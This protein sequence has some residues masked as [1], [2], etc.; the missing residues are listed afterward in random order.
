VVPGPH[1]LGL[2]VKLQK[3]TGVNSRSVK[4]LK[5]IKFSAK[6][7]LYLLGV[8]NENESDDGTSPKKIVI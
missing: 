5:R 7:L 1:K 8:N 4:S 6:F 3:K 2:F